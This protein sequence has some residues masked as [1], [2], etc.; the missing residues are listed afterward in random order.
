MSNSQTD[1]N[2]LFII[3]LTEVITSPLSPVTTAIRLMLPQSLTKREFIAS[4]RETK[5]VV[6]VSV[7]VRACRVCAM[8]V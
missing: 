7:V 6:F 4:V 8:I 1:G 2:S 3:S 5:R